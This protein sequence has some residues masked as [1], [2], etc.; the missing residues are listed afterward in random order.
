MVF[1]R[2]IDCENVACIFYQHRNRTYWRP[3]LDVRRNLD[4]ILGRNL[5]CLVKLSRFDLA[6]SHRL[7]R[8]TDR[9]LVTR[10]AATIPV[11]PSQIGIRVSLLASFGALESKLRKYVVEYFIVRQESVDLVA[12]QALKLSLID[13][14]GGWSRETIEAL[15]AS[16]T[17]ASFARKILV[18]YHHARGTFEVFREGIDQAIRV[19]VYFV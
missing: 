17:L 6:W 4:W 18:L 5:F 16:E 7:S 19:D 3:V 13:L 10:S 14:L 11:V 12:N 9:P 15:K 2:Q 1:L 8:W